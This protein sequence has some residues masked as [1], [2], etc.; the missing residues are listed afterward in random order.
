MIHG[1]FE[2]EAGD[3]VGVGVGVVG[4]GAGGAGGGTRALSKVVVVDPKICKACPIGKFQPVPYQLSCLRCHRNTYQNE[5]GSQ[6]CHR[7]G[8]GQYSMRGQGQCRDCKLASMSASEYQ[9]IR[10]ST[11]GLEEPGVCVSAHCTCMC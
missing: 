11:H 1:I 9:F 8:K 5:G 6:A 7:C 4:V 3:G 10:K 2:K